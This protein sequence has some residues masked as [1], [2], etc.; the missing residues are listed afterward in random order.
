MIIKESRITTK[1]I[2]NDDDN[3]GG[4]DDSNEQERKLPTKHL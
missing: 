3:D 2:I 1:G 4:N